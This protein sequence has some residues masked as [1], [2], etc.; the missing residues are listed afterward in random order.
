MKKLLWILLF[1]ALA[2]GG[3]LLLGANRKAE[4]GVQTIQPVVGEIV[5]K[6]VA[7][8]QIE[9]LHE[10]A[11]KSKNSG[12]VR[13][14]YVEVGDEVH[15][16][17]P[18]I[19]IEPDPTPL[20]YAEAKRYVELAEV[21]LKKAGAAYNRHLELKGQGVIS[22]RDYE[23]AERAYRDSEVRLTL[24]EE[25][26][27]LI[28]K[29]KALIADRQV[30]TTIKS[31]I[32]G[33]VLERRVN[34]GDPVVPLTSYQAGTQL[35]SL[36]D[37]K[38][39]LFRGTVDEIDVGKISVGMPATIKIGALPDVLVPARLSKISPKA[40]KVE[41]A[42]V[43]DVEIEILDA[44]EVVIRAG[45]SANAE[46]VLERAE[47]VL[48]LPERLVKFSSK[49]AT[50]EVLEADGRIVT[51][52]IEVGLSDGITLEVVSGLTEE[53]QVVERPPKSI[54]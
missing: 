10:I 52:E 45:Y 1:I 41:N 9:P 24:A 30:E 49:K 36:A 42:T 33:T 11:V 5:V 34:E 44:G 6:A 40:T 16:G 39:L 31:P 28:D 38:T 47:N 20:E 3:Y 35:L 22:A 48:I 15:P 27:Q 43:F 7:M 54:I 12:I 19:E 51:R 21:E 29:G 4:D 17:Q 8:G 37:M 14:I 18:L 23:E 53:D 2:V 13:R 26:L 46:V 32:S 50:V 25:R